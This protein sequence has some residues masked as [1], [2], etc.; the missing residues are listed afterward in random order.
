M[1]GWMDVV[2]NLSG[3]ELYKVDE[4]A[5]SEQQVAAIEENRIGDLDQVSLKE[6]LLEMARAERKELRS[7][8][9]T[10]LMHMLKIK[11]QPEKVSRS[12]CLMV[13]NQQSHINTSLDVMPSLAQ[14]VD[15]AYSAAYFPAVREAAAET[16][17]A[18]SVFPAANPWTVEEALGY[19]PP[20]F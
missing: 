2:K 6:V 20:E 3:P 5:W 17:L 1:R 16:G 18:R 9:T 12:W 13:V 4:L 15:E 10:L 8:F 19:E 14:Y 7:R 11:Y